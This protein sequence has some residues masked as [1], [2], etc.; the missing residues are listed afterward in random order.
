MNKIDDI[1]AHHS[2]MVTE[3]S[4]LF[5]SRHSAQMAL[6]KKGFILLLA[7]GT[8]LVGATVWI[9]NTLGTIQGSWSAIMG[10]LFTVT[11]I[12]LA[13]LQ[14][15]IQL[16]APTEEVTSAFPPFSAS[17]TLVQINRRRGA[18]IV[19]VKKQL[20]GTTLILSRGFDEANHQ[21]DL[22]ANVAE[23]TIGLQRLH[24]GVFPSLEPGNYTIS[25]AIGNYTAKVTI[26]TGHIAII[27]WR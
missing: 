5:Y 25:T 21:L 12:I 11:G 13:L 20:R 14:L 2:P 24:I 23:H 8:A 18:L 22:A 1:N 3:R 16:T 10:I 7:I 6:Q 15:H 4:P 26:Y 17:H 27:D 9:L 19:K